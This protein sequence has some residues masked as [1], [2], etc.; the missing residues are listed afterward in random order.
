MKKSQNKIENCFLQ[1]H[2]TGYALVKI[3]ARVADRLDAGTDSPIYLKLKNRDTGEECETG[4]LDDSNFDNWSRGFEERFTIA[5]LPASFIP[6]RFFSP[7]QNGDL[8]FNIKNTGSD[9]LLLES[10]KVYFD[11][12]GSLFDGSKVKAKD[13]PIL[14][15]TWN[16]WHWFNNENQESWHSFGSVTTASSSELFF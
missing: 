8:M 3:K 4:M 5:S 13:Y 2:I 15:F 6:C 9:D 1:F 12:Q 10:V 7:S 14:S 11:F 16:G